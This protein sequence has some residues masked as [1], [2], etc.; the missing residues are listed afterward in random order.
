MDKVLVEATKVDDRPV[1][2][3]VFGRRNPWLYVAAPDYEIL[4]RCDSEQTLAATRHLAD[5]LVL[6]K[7]LVPEAHLARLATP[8]SFIMFDQQ[9]SKAMEALIPNSLDDGDVF[10]FGIYHN[11]AGFTAGGSDTCDSD[12]HCAAQ[13]RWGMPWAWAGAGLGRGPIPTGLLFKISQ[14]AP[15]LP[16]WYQYGFIGP[17]G[18]LRMAPGS[19]SMILA[20][21]TWITEAETRT[22]LAEAK[23]NG[24]LPELPPLADL[25]RPK[26]IGEGHSPSDWPSPAWMAEAALFLRWGL[27]AD[28]GH[29]RAFDYF[30]ERS[31]SEPV[32]DGMFHECFG[33]GLDEMQ[34]RLSRYLV[35]G[36]REPV[37]VGYS[38]LAHWRPNNDA[39]HPP[40]PSLS[41]REATP[42]EVARLLG[43]WERMEGDAK[44]VSDPAMSRLYLRRAGKT[45]NQ[46]YDDGERDPRFLAV[47][48]LYDVDV[49]ADS[50]AWEVLKTATESGVSRPAAYVALAQLNYENALQKAAVKGGPLSADQIASV[51]KPLFAVRTRARLEAKG[52]ILIANAWSHSVQKPTLLNLEVLREGMGLYPFES[53]LILS[54]AKV[55]AQWGFASEARTWIDQGLKS[56]DEATARQLLDLQMSLG[57]EK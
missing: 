48:G 20:S 18:L 9:P 15:S 21:A 42:S 17:C 7:D 56:V 22:L 34:S 25:F 46:C 30:I 12:A 6:D 45:L 54:S 10:Y 31:R 35:D 53:A 52:Y 16:L 55:Y 8:M 3:R 38:S 44:R 11:E 50:E 57:V 23:R 1:L 51:L 27:Y 49:G 36:A 14:C 26:G 37:R 2:L 4:S 19:N 39:K 41:A 13:N 29:R 28:R 47:L 5:S 43:D 32:T 33:F 40:F 24:R